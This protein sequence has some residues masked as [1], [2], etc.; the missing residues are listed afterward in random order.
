MWGVAVG[1]LLSLPLSWWASED[2]KV[3][4]FS[5]LFVAVSCAWVLVVVVFFAM[6]HN[7]SVI[8]T[9]GQAT[10]RKELAVLI[11]GEYENLATSDH[12]RLERLKDLLDLDKTVYES[13]R[14]AFGRVRHAVQM[15]KLLL[16]A[17][18]PSVFQALL[19]I[20]LPK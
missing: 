7:L 1:A 10:T 19:H 9:R 2:A 3:G 4:E 8:V 15:I 5:L 20:L 14:T 11:E 18:F 16:V 12:S 17:A 13:Y 6:H